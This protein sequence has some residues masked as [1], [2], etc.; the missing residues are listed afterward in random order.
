MTKKIKNILLLIICCFSLNNFSQDSL[1]KKLYIGLS[2]SPC[3]TKSIAAVGEERFSFKTGIDFKYKLSKKIN[4]ATALLIYVQNYNGFEYSTSNF[5]LKS[6]VQNMS[7][8][9]PIRLDFRFIDKKYSPLLTA[10]LTTSTGIRNR[11]EEFYT[12]STGFKNNTSSTI[13]NKSFYKSFSSAFQI[14]FGLDANIKKLKFQ[15]YPLYEFTFQKSIM[16]VKY[17]YSQTFGLVMS[18]LYGL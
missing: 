12:D 8:Q 2:F 7:M 6:K 13:Y 11:F 16:P 3:R 9:I 15:L 4:L 18:V 17:H 5:S 1:N 14:G 10:G